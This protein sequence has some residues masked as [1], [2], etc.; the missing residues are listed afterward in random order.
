MNKIP[1]GRTI[2]YAY[3]FA[4]GHLG[5]IIGLIWIPMV[6]I[7]ALGFFVMNGYLENFS[8]A[9]ADENP[10]AAGQYALMVIGYSFVALLLYSMIYVAVTRQALD[11]SR[12]VTLAHVEIGAPVWRMFGALLAFVFVAGLFYLAI[13]LV[14]LGGLAAAGG[15]A[16]APA[17]ASG[18]AAAML[19]GLSLLLIAALCALVYVVARLAFLLAP[20]VVAEERMSLSRSWQLTRGNFWRIAI[21]SVATLG[22]PLLI[23]FGAEV[24]ILGPD[25]FFGGLN[26]VATAAEQAAQMQ[27][28]HSNLPALSGLSFLLSPFLTGLTLGASAFAY[29]ALVPAGTRVVQEA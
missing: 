28:M 4:F 2:A 20:V 5:T 24:L 9:L 19:L 13:F 10:S 22:P 8:A 18:A 1:V 15:A 12:A 23:M 6:L 16:P 29:R 25:Y 21:V 26:P 14:A 11:Q 3:S 17:A 27:V 7:T